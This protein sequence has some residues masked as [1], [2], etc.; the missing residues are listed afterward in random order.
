M[1]PA[2]TLPPVEPY[3]YLP[4]DVA[5]DPFA[6]FFAVLGGSFLI[7]LLLVALGVWA[8]YWFIRLAVRHAG[9]DVARWQRAGMPSRMPKKVRPRDPRPWD[10][11]TYVR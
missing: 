11:N 4:S 7:G 1:I 6:A 2:A 10:G 8:F 9:M 5:V 3:P